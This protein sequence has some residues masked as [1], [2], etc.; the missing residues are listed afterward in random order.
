M[1]HTLVEA[2]ADGRHDDL[3]SEEGTHEVED[4]S[5]LVIDSVY[6]DDMDERADGKHDSSADRLEQEEVRALGMGPLS[7]KKCDAWVE[8]TRC[9]GLMAVSTWIGALTR[10]IGRA[11]V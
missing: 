10:Q 5:L 4:G 2:A 6:T 8:L 1:G 11:H 9:A 3:N 7:V